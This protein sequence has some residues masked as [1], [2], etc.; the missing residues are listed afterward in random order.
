MTIDTRMREIMSPSIDEW[1]GQKIDTAE[2]ERRKE[3]ARQQAVAEDSGGSTAAA[4]KLAAALEAVAVAQQPPNIDDE[5]DKPAVEARRVATA[6]SPDVPCTRKRLRPRTF[7]S[8]RWPP[9]ARRP[10]AHSLPPVPVCALTPSP[11]THKAT[12]PPK[13][14]KRP[15]RGWAIIKKPSDSSSHLAANN[16]ATL[17]ASFQRC[18]R[19]GTLCGL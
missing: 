16:V 17:P 6:H 11:C 7:A 1:I 2:L 12:E 9:S 8:T 19:G 15:S 5:T 13:P 3:L 14:S 18:G 4:T 10:P